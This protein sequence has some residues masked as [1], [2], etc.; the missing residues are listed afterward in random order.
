MVISTKYIYRIHLP[1][2]RESNT[3][4]ISNEISACKYTTNDKIRTLKAEGTYLKSLSP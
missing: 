2:P 1:M 4:T 3:V